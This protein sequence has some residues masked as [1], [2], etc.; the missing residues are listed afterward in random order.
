M[1]LIKHSSS[2]SCGEDL[3]NC[4][5]KIS[6]PKPAQSLPSAIQ[7]HPGITYKSPF[8]SPNVAAVP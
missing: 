6:K 8:E 1:Y 3:E 7:V 5:S 4:M 2:K